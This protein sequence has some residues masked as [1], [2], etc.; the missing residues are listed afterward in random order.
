M[1][2]FI[3]QERE[4]R[5][6]ES[7]CKV[8]PIAPSTYYRSK[9][10]SANPDQRSDRTR[11]DEALKPEIAHVYEENLQVYGARKV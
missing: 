4:R 7:I 6:V 5:G 1:V 10:L 11:R 2:A 9:H 3:D 8:L